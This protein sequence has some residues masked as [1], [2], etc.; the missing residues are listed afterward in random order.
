MN[1][2]GVFEMRE[3]YGPGFRIYYTI[4]GQKLVVILAGS[5]KRD[6]DKTIEK[7]KQYL[8]QQQ[9]RKNHEQKY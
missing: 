1:A 5:I 3:D 2:G 8:A 7:A 4:I 9:K 6:Q